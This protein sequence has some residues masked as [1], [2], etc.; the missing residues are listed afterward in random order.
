LQ[1]EATPGIFRVDQRGVLKR[2]VKG[3]ISE[4]CKHCRRCTGPVN[5]RSRK[6]YEIALQ[7]DPR[8]IHARSMLAKLH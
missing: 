7:K 8:N 2:G 1:R 3:N 5:R 6:Y 4:P